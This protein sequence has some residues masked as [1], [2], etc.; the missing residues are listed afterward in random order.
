MNE[1]KPLALYIHWPFC[2]SK[3]PYCDFNSHVAQAIPQTLYGQALLQELQHSLSELDHL[4]T[5]QLTSIF[6]GG[7]TPSLMDPQM[8]EKLIDHA[9]QSLSVSQSIEIT[10]EANPTSVEIQK[11]KAFREAGVNRVSLGIQS[12]DPI[13]L[14]AL[15]RQHNVQQAIEALT[16]AKTL[17]PRISFDLIYA[18][19][20][21]TL[22]AWQK[23][24]QQALELANDHLSLY[25]L[26]LEPGTLFAKYNQQ[27]KLHL[28][29]EILSSEM[30]LA[31]EALTHHYGMKNYEISNYAKPGA[32]SRHNL[33]YW[34]YQDY[35]GIG[36]GAHGRITRHKVLYATER[37]K[38][39]KQWLEKVQQQGHALTIKEPLDTMEKAHEML[40]MGLRLQEGIHAVSFQ[41]RCGIELIEALNH[42][43]LNLLVEE[44]FLIWDGIILKTTQQGKMKLNALL[45][46][47]LT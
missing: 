23:E 35:I 12:L 45:E 41:K 40:L 46:A 15:G 22:A 13:A 17:F 24:L 5:Y 29:D 42:D 33:A 4:E 16:L 14:Q 44:N 11:L 18:R 38:N 43:K 20:G 19:E 8:V 21:Q 1:I 27:G 47:L 37:Y 36:P 32:E 39:P 31:T 2:L 6:F 9:T 25:Q 26:T 7:G 3:C 34:R 10:L 30:L 28:P